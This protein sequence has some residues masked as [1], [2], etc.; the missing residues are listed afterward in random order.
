MRTV[1]SIC[2]A[3]ILVLVLSLPAF[4]GDIASPGVMA[5]E[6]TPTPEEEAG[7]TPL[8]G[9]ISTPGFLEILISIISAI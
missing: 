3:T 8:P 1:K 4:A 2:T 5:P 6:P 9:D 7:T